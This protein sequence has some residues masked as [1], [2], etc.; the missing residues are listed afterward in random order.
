MVSG[1]FP[2]DRS[3][4]LGN[5]IREDG[6]QSSPLTEGNFLVNSEGR[7]YRAADSPTESSFLGYSENRSWFPG[8]SPLTEGGFPGHS[9]GTMWCQGIPHG[10][11]GISLHNL[12]TVVGVQ[13]LAPREGD[14][15]EYSKDRRLCSGH[16]PLAEGGFSGYSEDTRWCPGDSPLTEGDVPR[17]SEGRRFFSKAFPTRRTRFLRDSPPEECGVLRIPQGHLVASR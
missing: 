9:E 13:V 17:N 2:T 11:K 8:N 10:Q 14:F 5:L 6:V 3:D 7:R 15:L 1:G 16:S 4:F 12:K